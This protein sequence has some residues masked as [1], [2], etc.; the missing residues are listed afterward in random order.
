MAGL[1]R[2]QVGGSFERGNCDRSR[3]S[4][5]HVTCRRRHVPTLTVELSE[6]LHTSVLEIVPSR[7][8]SI[9]WL[10]ERALL[11]K[12]SEGRTE[13]AAPPRLRASA[14]RIAGAIVL[15]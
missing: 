3:L 14:Y 5:T 8:A 15:T 13:E 9:D 2:S 10:V 11:D 4:S 12:V 1:P 6:V 7:F